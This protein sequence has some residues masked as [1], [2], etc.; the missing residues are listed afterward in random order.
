MSYLHPREIE[1]EV[2]PGSNNMEI[3]LV[4]DNGAPNP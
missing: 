2:Q 4:A 1:V 3:E